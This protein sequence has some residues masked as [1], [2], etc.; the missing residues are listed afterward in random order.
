MQGVDPEISLHKKRRGNLSNDGQRYLL[1]SDRKKN[2]SLCRCLQRIK[3]LPKVPKDIDPEGKEELQLYIAVT[4]G[5]VSSVLVREEARVQKPIYYL[6]HVL[7]GPEENYPQIDKL[8][9]DLVISALKLKAYFKAHPI[10]VVTEQ[11]IKRILSN[12]AQTGRLTKWAIEL[13]EFE[14]TFIPK[15]G[16]KAQV[17]ANFII[18]CTTRDPQKGREYIPDLPER[19][20]WTLYVDGA[21]NPEGSG[22]GILIQGPEGLQFEYAL[23]FSF[24]TTNNEAEYEAMVTGLLLAQSLSITRMVVRG[25]SKPVI[26][27]IRG[28]CGV[29]SKILQKYYAKANSLT[30]KFDYLVFQHIP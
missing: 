23:R 15:T 8:V 2:G 10:V 9:M 21:S 26:E 20:Q 27:Q 6:S 18:E 3:R 28:D 19:P 4:N 11:P 30:T 22:A 16:V 17:L 14:I 13:S 25:D 12:P 24:K 1:G 7:H 5:A 29:Q